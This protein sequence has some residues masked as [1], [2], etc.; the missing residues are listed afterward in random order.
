PG[1]VRGR[2]LRGKLHR[3]PVHQQRP[4]IVGHLTW[5]ETMHGVVLEQIGEIT[6]LGTIVHGHDLDVRQRH[7]PAQNHTT[8]TSQSVNANATCHISLLPVVLC[9]PAYGMT[10]WC[11]FCLCPPQSVVF[12]AP[13]PVCAPTMS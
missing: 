13:P 8:N 1:N 3:S 12:T 4:R 11:A 10:P 2:C 5:K 9:P 7:G 6:Q